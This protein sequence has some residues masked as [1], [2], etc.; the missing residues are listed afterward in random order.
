MQYRSPATP[1]R[2]SGNYNW[3]AHRGNY[4]RLS[5]VLG[6]FGSSVSSVDSPY[7]KLRYQRN[8]SPPKHFD[9]KADVYQLGLVVVALYRLMIKPK[10]YWDQCRGSPAG[11]G[12]TPGLNNVLKRCSRDRSVERMPVAGLR[13]ALNGPQIEVVGRINY[14]WESRSVSRLDIGIRVSQ[15]CVEIVLVSSVG[16]MKMRSLV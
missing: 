15:T 7:I 11:A 5:V 10:A 14:C 2:L 9:K 13:Q 3:M 12:Y 1:A 6:D 16:I 8:F 4:P